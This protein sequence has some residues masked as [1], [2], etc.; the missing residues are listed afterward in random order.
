MRGC[1][2]TVRVRWCLSSVRS[3]SLALLPF[4][5]QGKRDDMFLGAKKVAIHLDGG[6][7]EVVVG[8]IFVSPEVSIHLD[9]GDA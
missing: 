3:G 4:L 7:V 5:R 8:V 9:G 2:F 6:D 1:D